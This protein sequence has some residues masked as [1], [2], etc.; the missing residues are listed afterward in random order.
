MDTLIKIQD[1]MFNNHLGY[2][3]QFPASYGFLSNSIYNQALTMAFRE[4][5]ILIA[6]VF[7]I[8]L[9]PTLFM[10]VKRT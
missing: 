4:G 5:F 9:V 10:R 2:I 3:L 8:A 6:I 7:F 1:M